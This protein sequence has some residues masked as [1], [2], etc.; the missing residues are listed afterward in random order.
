MLRALSRIIDPDF[1]MDIV[2]CGFVKDLTIDGGSGRVAFRLELTTPACPIKDEF[3]RKVC[4]QK[5]SS[6]AQSI[7]AKPS[8][9]PSQD[10]VE[11]TCRTLLCRPCA[12]AP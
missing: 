2:A 1:G 9:F 6:A 5:Q 8:C 11:A 10:C 4:S 12:C 3:E 7:P